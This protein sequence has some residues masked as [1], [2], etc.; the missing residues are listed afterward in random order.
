LKKLN[1]EEFHDLKSSPNTIKIITL[2]KMKRA[3]HVSR[4]GQPEGKGSLGR[5]RLRW[6]DNII[7][8]H[9]SDGMAR[10]EYI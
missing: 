1:G 3:E 10:P 2:R 4:M 8:C 7:M 9:K 5:P 6:E